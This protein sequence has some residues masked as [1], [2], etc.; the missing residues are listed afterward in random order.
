MYMYRRKRTSKN[1][2]HRKRTSKNVLR[3]NRTSK[4][5]MRRKI[6]GGVTLEDID[7]HIVDEINKSLTARERQRFNIAQGCNGNEA[8]KQVTDARNDELAR[9]KADFE[10]RKKG[11]LSFNSTWP[12][13]MVN[14]IFADP[15]AHTDEI[16]KL[17]LFIIKNFPIKEKYDLMVQ[18]YPK[19]VE[20]SNNGE[21]M[22]PESV[23]IGRKEIIMPDIEEKLLNEVDVDQFSNVFHARYYN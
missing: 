13:E 20:L 7:K 3:R 6:V 2:L 9:T 18:L 8:R 19:N 23:Y 11:M 4:K 22:Q 12:E 5:T 14:A 21:W 15:E 17:K 1:V 10:E 16:Q